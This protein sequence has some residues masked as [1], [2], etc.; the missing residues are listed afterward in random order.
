MILDNSGPFTSPDTAEPTSP[1][2]TSSRY[3]ELPRAQTAIPA[4]SFLPFFC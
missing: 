4:L 3:N 1:L 2:P